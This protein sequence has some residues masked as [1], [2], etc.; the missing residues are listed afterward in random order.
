MKLL[1]K[2]RNTAAVIGATALTLFGSCTKDI[3]QKPEQ[4][5]A[6][7]KTVEQIA[8]LAHVKPG[9]VALM[10][11]G[12]AQGNEIH[13]A[14][15]TLPYDPNIVELN[16]YIGACHDGNGV[17]GLISCFVMQPTLGQLGWFA[18]SVSL[19]QQQVPPNVNPQTSYPYGEMDR[20]GSKKITIIGA[21]PDA[22]STAY[23]GMPAYVW[24]QSAKD[25]AFVLST[26]SGA[27][28]A[29]GQVA[30][31]SNTPF[32][33]IAHVKHLKT[34]AQ[35]NARLTTNRTNTTASNLNTIQWNMEPE[36]GT[37]A[38]SQAGKF[39]VQIQ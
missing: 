38:F 28:I 15:D 37:R 35:Q 26:V 5:D 19:E 29:V 24:N 6:N 23:L 36:V 17:N 4:K 9:N 30:T 39:S 16:D 1:K 13:I 18:D 12:R 2:L 32:I 20:N 33:Y 31:D 21:A 34:V 14:I 11:E 7:G 3:T 22:V 8:A 25:V 27:D 10:H